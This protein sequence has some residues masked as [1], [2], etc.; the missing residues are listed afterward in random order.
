LIK[1]ITSIRQTAL[2]R[3]IKGA[4]VAM[5]LVIVLPEMSEAYTPSE[6]R[7]F[8]RSI[9]DRRHRLNK[10]F[11]KVRRAQTQLIIVH[12]SE[13]GLK[14]TLKV[15]SKGKRLRRDRRTQGG[16]AHYVIARNGRTYRTLDKRYVADHAG[17]SMWNG[18]RDLSKRSIG[19]ELVGY[20]YASISDRQY[21]SVGLLIEILQRV[22][23]LDDRAV[24]THSQVAYDQPN[25]W[26]PGNH[27]GRKRCAKNFIR[28]KAGLSSGWQHDPDVKSGRLLP[29]PQLARIFYAKRTY[30]AKRDDA[31][32]ITKH[33]TAWAI[34]GGDYDSGTTVYKLP[35]RQ[36]YTGDEVGDKIG[37]D[38]VPVKTVV[39]LNQENSLV[40]LKD[41]GPVKTISETLTAWSLAGQA[42]DDRT[43]IYFLP[44]GQIT[45]GS[46]MSD[47]DDLPVNTKLII[48]YRG[49]YPLKKR[50]S[51]YSIAGKKYNHPQTIYFLPSRQLLEG[52]KVVDFSQLPI[53]T[54]IFLP[55]G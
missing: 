41:T 12:T 5:A 55:T 53:G 17:L 2:K 51:A 31:N 21:R 23:G 27:R 15:V 18:K 1:S 36:V 42:Y 9:V 45:A 22:Y 32:V 11:K 44:G 16:H 33:N 20:H 50:Q 35:N 46:K 26:F 25:R 52:D 8:Q 19:I 29:D 54:L 14:T 24:L 13:L 28:A 40:L 38:R 7:A 4:V 37:W 6:R 48:G 30:T 3:V 34:A 43:T 49:P 10:R 39:L 47:W